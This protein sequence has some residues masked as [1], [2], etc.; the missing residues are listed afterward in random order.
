MTEGE[1][2]TAN[3]YLA[4]YIRLVQQRYG[5][6]SVN[7]RSQANPIF[8][9]DNNGNLL[10]TYGEEFLSTEYITITSPVAADNLTFDQ[11]NVAK[12]KLAARILYQRNRGNGFQ[13]LVIEMPESENST[14]DSLFLILSDIEV[15]LRELASMEGLGFSIQVSADPVLTDAD[16]KQRKRLQFLQY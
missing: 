13:Y 15:T 2:G 4:E 16:D 9:K 14:T 10:L 3:P 11:I 5:D 6:E 7:E 8:I 12:R 1:V